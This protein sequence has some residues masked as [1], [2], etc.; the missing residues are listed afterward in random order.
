LPSTTGGPSGPPVFLSPCG[1][2]EPGK[3]R[4]G[5]SSR[6]FRLPLIPTGMNLSA[7]G[8]EERAAPGNQS[9][10]TFPRPRPPK[11][12]RAGI[13][14]SPNH[15]QS[16][17]APS[18]GGIFS[19]VG[20]RAGWSRPLPQRLPPPAPDR[21]W[22][23]WGDWTSLGSVANP[24]GAVQCLDATAV[25]S[26]YKFYRA[27]Q[28]LSGRRVAHPQRIRWPVASASPPGAPT[29]RPHA[30]PGQR[31]GKPRHHSHKG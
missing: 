16:H 29:A 6:P 8:F 21:G 10:A 17:Q 31:P 7:W 15:P 18:R 30:S 5:K 2:F 25:G 22:P 19:T 23:N 28:R 9:P 3:G 13:C 24:T 1:V 12:R 14:V 20:A 11:A 27:T 26:S 4:A